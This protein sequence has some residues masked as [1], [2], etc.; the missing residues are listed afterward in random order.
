MQVAVDR[1]RREGWNAA[2]DA[3]HVRAGMRGGLGGGGV[4]GDLRRLV[5][6]RF[7]VALEGV[8]LA[9]LRYLRATVTAD[10]GVGRGAMGSGGFRRAQGLTDRTLVMNG[11]RGVGRDGRRGSKG[12]SASVGGVVVDEAALAFKEGVERK[13]RKITREMESWLEFRSSGREE[14]MV[15]KC[16]RCRRFAEKSWLF[17][18]FDG[19]EIE[20]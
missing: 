20:R 10:G 6:E 11:G 15:R 18:P 7:A 19:E 17:C 13:L 1:A 3:V 16:K 2:L 4:D 5:G 12:V 14:K 8:W 9:S